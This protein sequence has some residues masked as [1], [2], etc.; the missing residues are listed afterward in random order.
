VNAAVP[1]P[2]PLPVVNVMNAA[3]L[4]AVHVHRYLRSR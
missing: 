1:L 2:V 4:V 3:L